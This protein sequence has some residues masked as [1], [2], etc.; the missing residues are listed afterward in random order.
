MKS[1]PVIDPS[2]HCDHVPEMRR[3]IHG[4]VAERLSRRYLNTYHLETSRLSARD[5][6]L[7]GKRLCLHRLGALDS[8]LRPSTAI[9]VM[10]A[11]A[12]RGGKRAEGRATGQ[13][14]P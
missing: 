5:R 13:S 4:E 11:S 12:R 1:T 2:C 10:V 6:G 3:G 14:R 9:V 7:R 8:P